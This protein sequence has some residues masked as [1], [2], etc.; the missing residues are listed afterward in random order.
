MANDLNLSVAFSAELLGADADEWIFSLSDVQGHSFRKGHF[1]LVNASAHGALNG[2]NVRNGI[3]SVTYDHYLRNTFLDAG[4]FLHTL[5]W[6]GSFAYGIDLD[7]DR[8]L[9][10]GYSNG[11]RGYSRDAFTGDKR[12]LFSVEDRIFLADN[13]FHL[14]ALGILVFFDTGFVWDEGQSVDLADLRYAVGTGLRVAF[15]S[16]AGTN[17]LRLTWGFPLG[18]GVDPFGDSVFTVA[19]STGF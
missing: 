16:V 14:V 15:P 19:T 18:S 17:V 6:F 4:S 5:H 7:P 11:F 13:L 1:L 10:L 9:G 12:L 2:D 8:L 3:F